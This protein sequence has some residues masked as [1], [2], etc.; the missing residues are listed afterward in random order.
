MRSVP[1]SPLTELKRQDRQTHRGA[2]LR[3]TRRSSQDFDE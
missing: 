2:S 3:S 1:S